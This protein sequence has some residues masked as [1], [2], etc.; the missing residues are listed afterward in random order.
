MKER[1]TKADLVKKVELIN[2]MAGCFLVLDYSYGGCRVETANGAAVFSPRLSKVEM[3]RWLDAMA[4]GIE[5]KH[6][7]RHPDVSAEMARLGHSCAEAEASPE[8]C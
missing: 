6:A 8:E 5:L 2:R 7:T 1:T 4:Q 3:G